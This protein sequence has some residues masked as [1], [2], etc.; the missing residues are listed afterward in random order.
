MTNITKLRPNTSMTL[1]IVIGVI[2]LFTTFVFAQDEVTEAAP[3]PS[4]LFKDDTCTA[5]CWF[6]ITPGAST[7]ADVET[8]LTRLNDILSWNPNRFNA[9]IDANTGYIVRG[10][11]DFF[12][13]RYRGIH[14]V[15]TNNII[16]IENGVVQLISVDVNGDFA[17]EDVFAVYGQ[18]DD[19]HMT[20]EY[21]GERLKLIYLDRLLV[22]DLVSNGACSIENLRSDLLV[23][24]VRY[25]SPIFA[26]V[27]VET[28]RGSQPQILAYYSSLDR[29]IPL[30]VWESWLSGEVEAHCIEAWQELPESVELPDFPAPEGTPIIEFTQEPEATALPTVES[31]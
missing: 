1:M 10:Q 3:V 31:K 14:Q 24:G 27:P 29:Q 28:D 9:I 12:W 7:S 17:L 11:Y 18:P 2:C 20:Q 19:I 8:T 6:G 21:G 15:Q 5:P 4:S 25:Y 30:D 13:R 22:I 16:S 26:L 23:D